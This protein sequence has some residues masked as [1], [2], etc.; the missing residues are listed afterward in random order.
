MTSGAFLVV[1]R[2]SAQR[3]GGQMRQGVNRAAQQVQRP[4]TNQSQRAVST[5]T[6]ATTTQV[7]Q[8]LM[9][10]EELEYLALDVSLGRL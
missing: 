2:N 8:R 7:T 4:V 3:G 1:M 5:K 10:Q 9:T 6:A